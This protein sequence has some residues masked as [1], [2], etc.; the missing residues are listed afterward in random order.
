VFFALVN[1][2][3]TTSLA[4]AATL[5]VLNTADSGA[6]SLRQAVADAG[7][8]D[9]LVFD[10]SAFPDATTGTITLGSG[11][12]V[13]DKALTIEGG[14]K[15]T[16]DGNNN[17]RIFTID[18]GLSPQVN[19]VLS[20]LILTNGN[21]TNGGAIY[22]LENLTVSS[23]VIFSNTATGDGGGIYNSGAAASLD[24]TTLFGNRANRGGA[25]FNTSTP[26][27]ITNSTINGNSSIGDGG[28][29]FVSGYPTTLTNSTVSDNT[30]GGSGGGLSSGGTINIHNSTIAYNTAASRGGGI[31][32]NNNAL[33]LVSSI[34]SYNAAPDGPPDIR[35]YNNAPVSAS[36]SLVTSS[37]NLTDGVAGNIVGQEA[38]LDI[39]RDNGGP[40]MTH[41]LLAG[42]PCIATGSNPVPLPTDQRGAGF[43]REVGGVD[44][45]SVETD[46]GLVGGTWVVDT[47]T[48]EEN[49]DYSAGNLSLREAI[50]NAPGNS[51]ISFDGTVFPDPATGTLTLTLG[52][53]IINKTL[54]I[55]GGNRVT[56][57]AAGTN[58]IFAI[59]DQTSTATAVQL[60]N[61][62]LTGGAADNGAAIW[63]AEDL[64]LSNVILTGNHATANGGA[65]YNSAG[66]GTIAGVNVTLEASSVTGNT[67]V[68]GG[69]IYSDQGATATV[70]D[71]T[72]STNSATNGGAIFNR[73]TFTLSGSTVNS[74]DAGNGG[75]FY[76]SGGNTSVINSTISGNTAT[77]TGAGV[78]GG[79][80]INISNSTVAYNTSDYKAGGIYI[81]NN[82]LNLTSS[83]VSNNAAT[84][85]PDISRYNTPTITASNSLVATGTAVSDGVD[86]NIV[87]QEAKLFPL[88]DYGGPTQTHA[89]MD[90]SPCIDNGSNPL[91]LASDQRGPGFRRVVD[92]IDMGAVETQAV[93]FDVHPITDSTANNANI[94]VAVDP[95]EIPHAVYERSGNIYYVKGI[96]EEELVAAGSRPAIAV[97]PDSVPQLVYTSTG[98]QFYVTR[99]GE[100][101]Q[102]P[103]S[104]STYN[105]DIDID[106]DSNN[107]A[108]ITYVAQI[109]TTYPSDT[110][111]GVDIGYINNIDGTEL[112]PFSAPL[113]VWR[114]IYENMGGSSYQGYYY[115]N[116]RIKIDSAGGYHIIATHQYY[117]RYETF[118]T[119]NYHILYK[120]NSGGG[121]SSGSEARSAAAILTINALTLAPDGSPRAVYTQSSVPYYASPT[122]VWSETA[123]A[124]VTLPALASNAAGVGLAYVDSGSV[125]LNYND[126]SGFGTPQLIATGSAPALG[127][128]STFVY[129]LNSDGVNNEVFLQTDVTFEAAPEVTLDPANRTV[130]YGDDAVFT[131]AAEGLPAPTLQWQ[132]SVDSGSSF[133]NIE[134][135][136]STTLTIPAVVPDVDGLMIQAVFTN[137]L[138]TATSAAATLTVAPKTLTPAVT[139]AAKP[140]DGLPTAAILSLDITGVINDD[141]VSLAGGVATFIDQNVG[142][143]KTVTVTE[144]SLSGTDAGK[145]QL[146]A[147]DVTTT[148]T[149]AAA[150]LTPGVSAGD[151]T[152]DGASGAIITGRS[153]GGVIDSEDVNLTGGVAVFDS[154]HTGLNKTV[155]VTGLSLD[156]TDAGNYVLTATAAATQAAVLAR[157][158]TVTAASDSKPYDGA[159]T[160][161]GTPTITTGSLAGADTAVWTQSF[162]NRNAGTGKT[163]TPAGVVSDG[164]GGGN[165]AVTF[166]PGATG[167]ITTKNIT[168]TAVAD[169]KTYD[170]ST[171]S[172]GTPLISP[173]PVSGDTAAFLQTFDTPEAGTGKTLTPSG[174]VND[175][176]GGNNYNVSIAT[177][178]SGIIEKATAT[179]TI[180]GLSHT[181]DGTAKS[182]TVTTN[183][184]GLAV[185]VTYDD[186]AAAPGN[187]GSYA[188]AAVINDSNYQGS[189]SDTLIIAQATPGITWA[190]PADIV[191]GTALGA[192]Q[193]NATAAVAGTFVYTPALGTVPGA[194]GNQTL[195]VSFTPD[196]GTNY[197]AATAAVAINVLK[198]AATIVVADLSHNYDGTAKPA[199]ATTDPEGL[200][201]ILTYASEAT[202]PSSA[203]TY[204][205]AAVINDSNYQGSTSDTLIIAKATPI[206]TWAAPAVIVYGTVLG[207]SQLNATVDVAGTFVYTPAPGTVLGTGDNQTLSVSFTPND[208][209]NY[210]GTTAAVAIEVIKADQAITFAGLPDLEYGVDDVQL[211]A[212][213][214]SG[215]AVTFTITA[216]PASLMEADNTVR[217]TGRGDVTITASQAGNGNYNAA[218]DELRSFTVI[219]GHAQIMIDGLIEEVVTRKY[220]GTAKNLDVTTEPTGLTVVITYDGLYDAPTEIGEYAFETWVDDPNYSSED[221]VTG[222][223]A[224]I[225]SDPFP[226]PMFLPAI[227]NN[228]K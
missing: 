140:Y 145:Y 7:S 174:A 147:G 214:S 157:S 103:M 94:D 100:A 184:A 143:D 211:T 138:G 78:W 108:H 212:T 67:A 85:D 33:T 199:T 187:T 129:Y 215:L 122:S 183:P 150:S 192:G 175:G 227:I 133:S 165:Y 181:Y 172:S 23:S 8:G 22:N 54:N 116:P 159:A 152:Y 124:G 86:G 130:S 114:G 98:G 70:S 182:A 74:N 201:V 222:T 139:V 120:T 166:T 160:S 148:A 68:S 49:A 105:G 28:A 82:A 110:S 92:S 89:L 132:S 32:I 20:G 171:A 1:I 9:I 224:I 81:N 155:T 41:M 72:L 168:V 146:P 6:G 65:I 225:K 154:R 59:N 179:L 61:L 45:G 25:I 26:V 205:V 153:L 208:G 200:A 10:G 123:L 158:I 119:R 87:G 12:I 202:A 35:R 55:D 40:T 216:G 39:L 223:L 206:I 164:N 125:Y 51:L 53:L 60:S 104:I 11:A 83:I 63:N 185:I 84:F 4:S 128:G 167:T 48:D 42:S 217:I 30:A 161:A 113:V 58:R 52:E 19:V 115:N 126:G 197:N 69:G 90:L 209:P 96:G 170:G 77:G 75:A 95:N 93:V 3:L 109:D 142:V 203:G 18:D 173:E 64:T 149:I 144:L 141:V 219:E 43:P 24:A 17:S 196:D 228:R 156:G 31:F 112:V 151:K 188:V 34:V 101:W 47:L 97:G 189:T 204:T 76:L 44:M 2:L 163:L 118:V 177:A 5:T 193:L 127:L 131:A 38:M 137:D 198:A 37:D 134:G 213:A 88:G 111:T 194:G 80:N 218:A 91:N 66:S 36:N 220:D 135:A 207:A 210:N 14:G 29:I 16:I 186:E 73:G 117:Y 99:A 136:T 221:K 107:K 180:S 71:I 190:A 121:F 15:V 46:T 162:D 79:G 169:T 13:T 102:A 106:V 57:D 226:W 176:N 56:I 191:Y 27:S 50:A 62:T 195:S 178:N 21:D